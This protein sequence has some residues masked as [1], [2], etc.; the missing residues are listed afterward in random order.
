MM[1]KPVHPDRSTGLIRYTLEHDATGLQIV[2]RV[3]G[4][5]LRLPISDREAAR[6]ASEI[7]STLE[8]QGE[9]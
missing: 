6:L 8:T 3:A 7:T 9:K 1:P 4:R 5:K 2:A